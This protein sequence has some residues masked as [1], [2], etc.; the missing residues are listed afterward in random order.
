MQEIGILK[1]GCFM[2]A[3][4]RRFITVA[5]LLALVFTFAFPVGAQASPAASAAANQSSAKAAPDIS[6]ANCFAYFGLHGG[7]GYAA[8]YAYAGGG[9][10]YLYWQYPLHGD[11]FCQARV[12]TDKTN[13]N[14]VIYDGDDFGY[15][16]AYNSTNG[17]VYL[18]ANCGTAS[19]EQW[20]FI[21]TPLTDVYL[22]Q[23]RYPVNGVYYCLQVTAA[24]SPAD[25]GPCTTHNHA[26]VLYYG[27]YG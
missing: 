17:Y 11:T 21:S 27:Y 19:Y 4:C 6:P 13:T 23:N 26:A 5:G 25:E 3:L 14:V 18:H 7:Y 15:C 9:F 24:G 1:G 2:R 10:S 12:S 20:K 8:A 16:L 22:L